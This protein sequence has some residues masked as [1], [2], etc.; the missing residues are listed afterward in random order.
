MNLQ[1]FVY[2]FIGNVYLAL[3]RKCQIF[4]ISTVF[5]VTDVRAI[6]YNTSLALKELF[7]GLVRALYYNGFIGPLRSFST[8]A[9]RAA[10]KKRSFFPAI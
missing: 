1:S 8:R 5:G 7:K 10:L 3:T 9:K 6:A 4:L 2:H